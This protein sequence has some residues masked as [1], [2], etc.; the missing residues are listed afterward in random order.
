VIGKRVGKRCGGGL[1]SVGG[2][3]ARAKARELVKKFVNI[4]LLR[5]FWNDFARRAREPR[6]RELVKM[7]KA[8]CW[9]EF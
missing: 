5:L 4:V 1:L 2:R 8:F 3:C 7:S 6:A 9:N